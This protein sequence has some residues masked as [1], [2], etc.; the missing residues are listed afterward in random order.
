MQQIPFTEKFLFYKDHN[1]SELGQRPWTLISWI[2]H[3][4]WDFVLA[5]TNIY[6][7]SMRR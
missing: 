5:E 2:E 7:Y 6:A 3:Q 4:K 1:L